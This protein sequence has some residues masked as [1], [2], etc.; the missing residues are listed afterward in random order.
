MME[1]I[2]QE[3]RD[4]I[5]QFIA[6]YNTL[7]TELRHQLGLGREVPFSRVVNEFNAKHRGWL[8]VEFLR[9]VNDLR[10]LLVHDPKRPYDYAAVPTSAIVT[11]LGGACDRILRPQRVVPRFARKVE[12][13]SPASSLA[14]VLRQIDARDFSQFPIYGKSFHGL[15]TENGITR[16]LAHHVK[17]ELSIVELE[18]VFVRDIVPEEE[19]RANWRFVSREESVE[20]VRELFAEKELLEAVLITQTGK[21]QESLLGIATRWDIIR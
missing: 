14:E 12:T 15:L 8:D 7:D 19:K 18:E 21:P 11:K 10:N 17:V 6:N 3:Q 2:T 9:T 4:L 13:V 1:Q 20:A 16:W 5:E